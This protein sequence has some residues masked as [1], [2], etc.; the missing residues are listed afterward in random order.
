MSSKNFIGFDPK[1]QKA[2]QQLFDF[3]IDKQMR[4]AARLSL[5]DVMKQIKANTQFEMLK[6]FDNPVPFIIKNAI[7]YYTIPHFND[8]SKAFG[9]VGLNDDF[10]TKSGFRPIFI[11]LL[12]HHFSS[13]KTSR[14][15]KGLEIALQRKNILDKGW[16]IVPGKACPMSP[17]GNIPLGF[18]KQIMSYFSAGRE[19]GYTS[20]MTDITRD[21]F[22]KKLAKANKAN[23]AEWFIAYGK[24]SWAMKVSAKGL[25]G[26]HPNSKLP[27]GIWQREWHGN[28]TVVKPIF[29]FVK[30][31]YYKQR[32]N[33]LKIGR[34]TLKDVGAEV[35]SLRFGKA[36]KT[37]RVMMDL[38]GT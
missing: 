19:A 17:P 4:F 7:T 26:K 2:L 29:I 35:F 34:D 22:K 9:W 21:K 36:M 8:W 37:S 6:V 13:T 31:T 38:R 33:L 11:D 25:R 30:K 3:D 10:R 27:A 12:A 20:N 28:T 24:G 5:I 14:N 1:A 18:A 16:Y 23:A 32:L 15:F